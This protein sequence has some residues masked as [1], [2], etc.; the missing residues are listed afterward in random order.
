MHVHYYFY[1]VISSKDVFNRLVETWTYHKGMSYSGMSLAACPS[2][3]TLREVKRTARMTFFTPT[4]SPPLFGDRVIFLKGV[5]E[6]HTNEIV[7]LLSIM[8]QEALN[9]QYK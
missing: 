9:V 2:L 8:K 1:N 6:K 3:R 7:G 4:G 5:H